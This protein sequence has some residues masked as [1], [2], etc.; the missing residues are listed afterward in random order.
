MIEFKKSIIHTGRRFTFLLLLF[1]LT[2][3][4]AGLMNRTAHAA[5]ET[6]QIRLKPCGGTADRTS[7]QV[8]SDGSVGRLPSATRTGYVFTG[9]YTKKNDGE[10]VT[11]KTPV[12]SL[13][14]HILYAHYKPITYQIRFMKNGVLD[15]AP[16]T[17][18]CAYGTACR[19][20]G[21]DDAALDHWSTSRS[22]KGTAYEAGKRV[23]NL[24]ATQGK[25][26]KLYAIALSGKNNIEKLVRYFVR[27]GYTK[28]A[29]AGIAGNL[30]YES[31]GGPN[32][33]KL[34]AVEYA[35]G[36]G[37]GMVQWTDTSDGP[38]RTNFERFCASRGKP[39]PNTDLKLQIEFLMLELEGKYGKI[40]AFYPRMGYPARY[41]MSLAAFK[42]CKSVVKATRVFCANFERPYAN[43]CGM[44]VRIQFAKIALRS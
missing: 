3:L 44:D 32:D 20:P 33:I 39:W 38:R 27:Q 35:T 26:I 13:T 36:R 6:V 1:I 22:D 15:K 31:G 28:E 18:V 11:E 34:N 29:A 41:K 23:K 12:A 24:T 4:S 8:S 42:R 14:K 10:I 25:T 30:M 17:I 2:G 7:V 5:Q 16:E 19:L 9:W 37:I 43:D 40:W 21:G